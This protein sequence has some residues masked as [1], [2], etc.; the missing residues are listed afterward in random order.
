[1][2]ADGSVLD[3]TDGIALEV[4]SYYTELF[5]SSSPPAEDIQKAT[6]FVQ[7]KISQP[8]QQL[9][10]VILLKKKCANERVKEVNSTH[11]VPILKK[12]EV[13]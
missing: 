7:Y 9:L 6:Q 3:D 4:S 10:D 2:A 8:M 11:V 12:I 13:F 5:Q 1:M